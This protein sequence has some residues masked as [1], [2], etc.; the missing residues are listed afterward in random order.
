M[1]KIKDSRGF[2]I[3]ELLVIMGITSILVGIVTINLLK[4]QHNTSVSSAVDTLIADIKGQQ[5]KAMNGAQASSN[6]DYGIYFDPTHTKYILFHGTTY[7]PA[8]SSNFPVVLE[9]SISVSS[10]FPNSIVVFSKPSGE[11]ANFLSPNNTITLTNTAGSE[12]AVITVNRYG[13]VTQ[14]Q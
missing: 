8:D 9:S 13:V 10:T 2:T 3:L 7:V 14:I 6:G 5:I 12:Q 4:V 11:V 1:K